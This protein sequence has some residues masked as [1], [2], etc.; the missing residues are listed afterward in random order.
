MATA[1]ARLSALAT[2]QLTRTLEGHTE[3]VDAVTFS[4][5]GRQVATRNPMLLR[6]NRHIKENV[7]VTVHRH[8]KKVRVKRRNVIRV[9]VSPTLGGPTLPLSPVL[10]DQGSADRRAHATWLPVGLFRCIR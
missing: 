9:A 3:Q 5:D 4:S 6:P 8:G 10:A 1:P 7:W 2:D